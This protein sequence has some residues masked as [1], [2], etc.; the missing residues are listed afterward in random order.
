MRN[1]NKPHRSRYT[2][3]SQSENQ[4]VCTDMQSHTRLNTHLRRHLHEPPVAMLLRLYYRPLPAVSSVVLL[5][6]TASPKRAANRRQQTSAASCVWF[7]V[8]PTLETRRGRNMPTV[9]FDCNH[10]AK[11]PAGDR[12]ACTVKTTTRSGSPQ[13]PCPTLSN[14]CSGETSTNSTRAATGEQTHASGRPASRA[15]S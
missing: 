3:W 15:W 14:R 12:V 2:T 7:P 8:I 5:Q 11:S 13:T 1:Q 9:S 4:S 6:S 10:A